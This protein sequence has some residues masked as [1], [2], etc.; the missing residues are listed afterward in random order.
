MTRPRLYPPNTFLSLL[1]LNPSYFRLD[2]SRHATR[3][4]LVLPPIDFAENIKS[5][6][7]STGLQLS[8]EDGM[9]SIMYPAVFSKFLDRR[10]QKGLLLKYLPTPVY[11]YAMKPNTD[12]DM[13]I[14][15]SQASELNIKDISALPKDKDGKVT[16][17]IALRRVGPLKD[18][19][20]EVVFSVSGND[21]I[22]KVKDTTGVFVFEGPMVDASDSSQVGSPMPGSIE[23]IL[24]KNGQKVEAGDTLMI[25][26]AMKMEVKTSAPCSGTVSTISVTTGAR[27]VEGALLCKVDP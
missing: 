20:R 7:E 26:G 18:R 4:G 17:N 6:C 22:A 16:V 27:V 19:F 10:A 13:T 1:S 21:Q 2:R 8:E 11:F 14:L 9:S 5:L 25:I 3:Q 15:P 24:V 23:K 12:F